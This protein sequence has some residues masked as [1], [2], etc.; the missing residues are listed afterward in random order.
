[1]DAIELLTREHRVVLATVR[2]LLDTPADQPRARRE[3]LRLVAH[4]IHALGAIKRHFFLPEAELEGVS[5]PTEAT[6]RAWEMVEHLLADLAE[7]SAESPRFD[8]KARGLAL[9]LERHA[10]DQEATVF[11][12]FAHQLGKGRLERLG[13]EMETALEVIDQGPQGG[14]ARPPGME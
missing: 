1:M 6:G 11:P 4:R 5:S 3:R 7:L 10:R 9:L 12:R 14:S 13:L 8:A 2:E